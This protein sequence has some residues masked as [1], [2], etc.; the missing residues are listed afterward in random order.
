ME[1]LGEKIKLLRDKLTQEELASL[2]SVDRSTLASWEVNR[3]EPDIATLCRIATF[4]QVSVDWLINHKIEQVTPLSGA[5]QFCETASE[6]QSSSDSSWQKVIAAAQAYGFDPQAVLQLLELNA[7]IA[8][9]LKDR[10]LK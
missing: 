6:Y 8:L 3:R 5:A 7:K 2:L 10:N 1:T 4:F 9:S